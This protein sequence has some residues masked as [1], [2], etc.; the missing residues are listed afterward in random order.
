MFC[1]AISATAG[2]HAEDDVEVLDRQHVRA[3]SFEPLGAGQRLTGRAV[4]IATRVVPDAPMAAAVTLFDVAAER[5]GAALLDGRHHPALRRRQ[6]GPDLGPERIA[7]AAEDFRHR[8]RGAWHGRRSVDALDGEG[9]RLQEQVQWTLGRADRGG[10]QLQVA[11]RRLQASMPE[12]EPNRA[13]VGAG[14]K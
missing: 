14:L 11:R 5:S 12:Q 6:G 1:A 13:Q 3:A 10:R 4:A 9:D 7:V 8:E 2:G